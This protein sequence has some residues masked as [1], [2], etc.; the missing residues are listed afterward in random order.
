MNLESVWYHMILFQQFGKLSFLLK[1][2]YLPDKWPFKRFQLHQQARPAWKLAFIHISSPSK[3]LLWNNCDILVRFFFPILA[4]ISHFII[5]DLLF[6]ELLL[7]WQL[8]SK[9][10]LKNLTLQLNSPV[11]SPVGLIQVVLWW[12]DFITTFTNG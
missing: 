11:S 6:G 4:S 5:F 3:A 8:T 7:Y 10:P 2:N 12:K 9:F 1:C